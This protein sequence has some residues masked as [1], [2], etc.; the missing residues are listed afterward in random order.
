MTG[1]RGSPEP[2]L[3]RNGGRIRRSRRWRRW[4]QRKQGNVRNRSKCIELAERVDNRGDADGDLGDAEDDQG[5]D[6]RLGE[7]ADP[8]EGSDHESVIGD[9]QRDQSGGHDGEDRVDEERGAIVGDGADEAE[10]REGEGTAESDHDRGD[11]KEYADHSA[12]EDEL[13]DQKD[14]K[15][16]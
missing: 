13:D 4:R 1:N 16:D 9:G 10:D 8:A 3:R 7:A 12:V 14:D 6:D 11:R 2:S 15:G 5:D